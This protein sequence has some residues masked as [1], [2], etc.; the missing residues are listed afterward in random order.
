MVINIHSVTN[1]I[2]TILCE[3]FNSNAFIV[4]YNCMNG[5]IKLVHLV[6]ANK[7]SSQEL[8]VSEKTVYLNIMLE[9]KGMR[10]FFLQLWEKTSIE[11]EYNVRSK[12]TL[13]EIKKPFTIILNYFSVCFPTK[14]SFYFYRFST[15]CALHSIFLRFFQKRRGKW[16]TVNENTKKFSTREY[17]LN[18][19]RYDE[20]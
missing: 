7:N 1:I 19:E 18:V 8:W 12:I 2:D 4:Y 6:D 17:H 14:Y 20:W 9:Y 13:N 11:I 3:K 15:K 5:T 10:Y 16:L